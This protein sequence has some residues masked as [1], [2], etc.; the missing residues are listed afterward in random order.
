MPRGCRITGGSAAQAMAT[1]ASYPADATRSPHL[2]PPPEAFSPSP[3]RIPFRFASPED[4]LLA[5]HGPRGAKYVE[6]CM[7]AMQA[8]RDRCVPCSAAI[9]WPGGAR[10]TPA[11]LGW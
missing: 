1:T 10:G 2:P 4:A 7:A 5:F 11:W 9:C 8:A 6:S 3:K